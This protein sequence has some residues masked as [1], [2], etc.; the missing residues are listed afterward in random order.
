MLY[1]LQFK[2]ISQA[3]EILSD[4]KKRKIYDQGGM[5]AL[6]EGKQPTRTRY[7]GHVTGYQ[8]IRRKGGFTIRAVWMP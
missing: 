8:P 6:K 3:F 2:E 7:L 1:I 4:E 5:E